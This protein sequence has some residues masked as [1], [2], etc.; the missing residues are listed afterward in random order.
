MHALK[1]CAHG[2]T[3]Y[4]FYSGL[5]FVSGFSKRE[6]F[7]REIQHVGGHG[8]LIGVSCDAGYS[9]SPI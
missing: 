6:S 9:F 7:A 3:F 5:C 1:Q 8:I 4:T 2:K